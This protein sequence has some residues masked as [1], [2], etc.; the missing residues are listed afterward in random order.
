MARCARARW[1]RG[2][3]TG[4]AILP[5]WRDGAAYRPLLGAD[6]ALFAWEWLRRDPDYQSAAA[7]RL[8]GPD[9][10]RATPQMFGLVAFEPAG[11]GVPVARPLWR[12]Q[13]CR[14]VLAVEPGTGCGELFDASRFAALA[15]VAASDRGEHLLLSDGLRQIRLDGPPQCFTSGPLR[16]RYVIEGIGSAE[17]A[18]LTLQ[19]LLALCRSG[20]FSRVLHRPEVRAR[21]WIMLL[22]SYDAF[23]AG[24]DQRSIA[25]VLLSESVAQSGWRVRES[26]IRLQVQRLVRSSRAI[27]AGGYRAL[28]R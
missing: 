24:A 7:Q 21:R 17:R 8:S 22:R 14:L 16:L 3:R 5:D 23:M 27:A 9:E 10:R 11:L 18:L 12:Q 1:S 25:A 2:V 28:L 4:D 15:G 19:R 20:R 26:S 13:D 6:R